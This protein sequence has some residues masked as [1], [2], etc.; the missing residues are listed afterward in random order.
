[1]SLTN[2]IY[3]FV[4]LLELEDKLNDLLLSIVEE[5]AAMIVLLPLLDDDDLTNKYLPL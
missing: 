2:D 3:H 5:S 1:M 4:V